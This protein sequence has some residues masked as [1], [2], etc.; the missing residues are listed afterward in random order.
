MFNAQKNT[1]QEQNYRLSTLLFFTTK[2]DMNCIQITLKPLIWCIY[3]ISQKKKN[4]IKYKSKME[5]INKSSKQK[6]HKQF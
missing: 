4:D 2:I 5:I 3:K 1:H 6:R